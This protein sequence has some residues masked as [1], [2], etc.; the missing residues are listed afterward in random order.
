[1]LLVKGSKTRGMSTLGL[2]ATAPGAGQ[3]LLEPGA[4]ARS[5]LA[6]LER[7][8]SRPTEIAKTVEITEMNLA[9][10][11]CE[12]KK[13]GSAGGYGPGPGKKESFA[14]RRQG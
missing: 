9:G 2:G 3:S 10:I 5:V 12:F 1:M 7:G 4:R 13:S 6:S 14:K 11:G 8:I